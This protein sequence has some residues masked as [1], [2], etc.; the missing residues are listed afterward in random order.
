VKEGQFDLRSWMSSCSRVR[1]SVVRT[2]YFVFA[3]CILY[4]HSVMYFLQ[5]GDSWPLAENPVGLFLP[6]LVGDQSGGPPGGQ[7]ASLLSP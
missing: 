5:R 3:K 4:V 1:S 7:V 2:W 6:G